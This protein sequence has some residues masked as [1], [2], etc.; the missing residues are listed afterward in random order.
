M[1]DLSLDDFAQM[2]RARR[3]ENYVMVRCPWH[4]D[5]EPSLLVNSRGGF[6]CLACRAHGS[7]QK[8]YNKLQGW[9]EPKSAVRSF[10]RLTPQVQGDLEDWILS[11]HEML[12]RDPFLHKY[13]IQRGVG[14]LIEKCKLGWHQGWYV[15]P[16]FGEEY[17]V[18][19]VTGRASPMTEEQ[20]GLRYWN[21]QAAVMYVPDWTLLTDAPQVYVVYGIFDALAL[22]AH[23]LPVVT[24][25]GG[26]DTFR[27]SWLDKYRVPIRVLPDLYEAEAAYQL[28]NRLGWRGEVKEINYP[29]KCKDPSDIVKNGYNLEELL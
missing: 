21:A 1:P 3:Y 29:E 17:D 13:L 9:E 11:A 12:M 10:Q 8:L 4:S 28:V 2:S 24:T 19:G 22:A 6:K 7:W 15:V 16:I 14:K 25:V 18:I 27:A 20:T 26:H 5:R 23:N